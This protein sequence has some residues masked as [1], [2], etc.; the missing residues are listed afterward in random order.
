[1]KTQTIRRISLSAGEV[2]QLIVDHIARKEQTEAI[3]VELVAYGNE[4]GYGEFRGAE[5]TVVVQA[6][7]EE[8]LVL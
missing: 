6:E 7:T 4:D 5:V 3:T 2:E 1:M 8:E